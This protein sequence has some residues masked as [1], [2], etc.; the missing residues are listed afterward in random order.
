MR[1][2]WTPKG[3]EQGDEDVERFDDVL[4]DDEQDDAGDGEEQEPELD[5]TAQAYLERRLEE[6]AAADAKAHREALEAVEAR[7]RAELVE[8]ARTSGVPAQRPTTNDEPPV[9]PYAALGERPD[10]SYE[11]D[12]ARE[13]DRKYR[14]VLTAE[15]VAAVQ[16]QM[17]PAFQ[18][19]SQRQ[20][21]SAVDDAVARTRA[22]L[23]EE[24]ANWGD[25]AGFD[26]AMRETLLKQDMSVWDQPEFL[27]AAAASVKRS[28]KAGKVETRQDRSRGDDGRYA[29]NDAQ[30]RSL[31]QVAAPRDAGRSA[32]EQPS[33][34]E[35]RALA[36]MAGMTV[37]EWRA[38]DAP[39]LE[40]HR[41]F[42]DQQAARNRGRR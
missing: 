8:L 33:D 23:D 30:R 15:T 34:A 5:E 42:Q 40:S 31:Q 14:A 27:F 3:E 38:Y 19:L 7:H 22:V 12:E 17:Q 36:E 2:P 21:T 4:D 24:G 1:W 32:G 35:E 20:A 41:R 25:I 18:Q 28:L 11:P 16:A 9:D 29:A 13:W 10:P 37:R 39:D 6:R 26:A